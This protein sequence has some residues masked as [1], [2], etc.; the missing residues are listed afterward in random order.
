MPRCP[1]AFV[2]VVA[3]LLLTASATFT[4]APTGAGVTTGRDVSFPQCGG[5]PLPRNAAF[6]VIG[7]N[8]GSAFTKNPCLASQ[9]GW[10]KRLPGAPAFYANTGNPGPYYSTHWPIGQR[11]PFACRASD[12]NSLACSFDYGW[13]AGID[14]FNTAT[15]GAQQLHHYSRATA[16]QHVA[17]VDWWLDVEILN[18]WQTLEGAYGLTPAS[19]RRD[20]LALVGETYALRSRGV[21]RVGIYSTTWQWSTI[22][23]GGKVI[24]DWFRGA[25]VWFAGFESLAH[26]VAGCSRP[27]FTAG[28]VLMTQYLGADQLDNN[29]W[30]G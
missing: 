18:S 21:Q 13:N 22:T 26:A 1:V 12:P 11:A 23:G 8:G 17:N 14:A 24:P 7:V 4:V 25:P 15:Y 10:A 3:A 6:G 27:T 19:G 29:V 28:P 2:A 30:C 5:A 9:L 16:S 20:A